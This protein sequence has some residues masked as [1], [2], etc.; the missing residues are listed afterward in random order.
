LNGEKSG[1]SK[2]CMLEFIWNDFW[3]YTRRFHAF[4]GT[5]FASEKR[6][7][8]LQTRH[9]NCMGGLGGT[10]LSNI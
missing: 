2:I 9:E 7:L 4:F 1:K 10:A 3:L 5:L 6:T 8:F